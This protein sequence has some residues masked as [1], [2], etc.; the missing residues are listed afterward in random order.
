[1]VQ[2]YEKEINK[3]QSSLKY[4]HNKRMCYCDTKKGISFVLYP[5]L[6][7]IDTLIYL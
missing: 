3:P 2:M 1:M 4:Y 7:I 5:F 6:E